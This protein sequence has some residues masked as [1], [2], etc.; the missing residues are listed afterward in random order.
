LSSRPRE[1]EAPTFIGDVSRETGT[2]PARRLIGVAAAHGVTLSPSDGGFLVALLDRMSLEAQNLTAIDGIAQGV[3]RHL[4][5]SIVGL[6][7]DEIRG[8]ATICDIGSGGGF[9]GLVLGR[10][11]RNARVTLVESERAKAK[12]LV[13]AAA[14]SPNVRVVHDRSEHLARRERESFDVVTARAVGAL[15]VV[16]ELA[17]PLTRVGG[18]AVLWRTVAEASQGHDDSNHL[19]AA[20]TLGFRHRATTEVMPFHGATRCLDVW[21]KIDLCPDKFPRRPGMATKRPL[22]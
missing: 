21:E 9:P 17:A 13:R 5:D 2:A 12:W 7:L 18:A 20:Q 14:D 11:C 10:M 22:G 4:A 6:V 8:A 15:A 3:D 16:L 19:E 1:T